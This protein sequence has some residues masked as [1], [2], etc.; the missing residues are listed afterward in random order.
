MKVLDKKLN[1]KNQ[2]E[3]IIEIFNIRN[4]FSQKIKE[5]VEKLPTTINS[6]EIKIRKDFREE[7]TFTIDPEDAKD[8]DDAISVKFLGNKNVEIGVHIADVGHYVKSKSAIDQ[9]AFLRAF[10]VYFPGKVVPMLPEKLSNILCSLRPNE[11]KLSFSIL[12]QMN[13][14]CQIESTWIGK[15]IINS[16]KRFSY[17]E[18]EQIILN[19]RGEFY[20]ELNT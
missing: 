9:E 7:I 6:Q 4:S 1:L 2:I 18:V 17:K 12:I 20:N 5:E 8:F 10:S 16:N 13:D 3:S 14:S 11:D 19:K 15:G